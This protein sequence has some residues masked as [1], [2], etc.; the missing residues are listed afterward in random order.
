MP[1]KIQWYCGCCPR[2]QLFI[3]QPKFQ[4]GITKCWLLENATIALGTVC[5]N[6]HISKHVVGVTACHQYYAVCPF[7]VI[8][9]AA[10]IWWCLQDYM[11]SIDCF[12]TAWHVTLRAEPLLRCCAILKHEF[13]QDIIPQS[14]PNHFEGLSDHVGCRRLHGSVIQGNALE[15]PEARYLKWKECIRLT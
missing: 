4:Q 1:Y 15:S 2:K 13:L 12:Y 8:V 6:V 11:L 9:L 7:V 10:S 3:W 5:A 14:V